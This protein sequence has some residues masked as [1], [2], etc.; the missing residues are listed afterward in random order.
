MTP[1]EIHEYKLTWLKHSNNTVSFDEFIEYD[2]KR[3]CRER[4]SQHR[5]HF[6]SY[7]DWYQHAISFELQEHKQQFEQFLE[8]RR[9]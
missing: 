6:T 2:C 1:I 5:W 9:L 8:A 7:V 4:V 3:W